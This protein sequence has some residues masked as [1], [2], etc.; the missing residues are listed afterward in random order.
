MDLEFTELQRR[1]AGVDLLTEPRLGGESD[2]TESI[3]GQPSPTR[4]AG[5]ALQDRDSV[6]AV[7]R[8]GTVSSNL[9]LQDGDRVTVTPKNIAGAF[10]L[11]KLRKLKIKMY[12]ETNHPSPHLHIDYGREHHVATYSIEQPQR[13]AG[14]LH[15]KYDRV[16]VEWITKN[17]DTLLKLWATVQAG[18]DP[19]PFIKEFTGSE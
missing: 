17:C 11:L 2:F 9:Q 14:N 10:Q 4:E 13:L 19:S 8:P 5:A 12:Q 3:D 18:N 16:V 6:S 7:P 1:L 15:R